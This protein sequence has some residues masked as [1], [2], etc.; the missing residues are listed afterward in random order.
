MNSASNLAA[1]IGDVADTGYMEAGGID[2][3]AS[4]G[5]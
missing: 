1:V 4:S 3:S 2:L 5:P